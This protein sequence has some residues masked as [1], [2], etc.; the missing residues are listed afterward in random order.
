ML[1][2]QQYEVMKLFLKQIIVSTYLVGIQLKY[3]IA[4]PK[5]NYIVWSK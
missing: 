4:K 5:C 2:T 1:I 3:S